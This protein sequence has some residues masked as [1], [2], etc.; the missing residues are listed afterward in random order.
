MPELEICII[1]V[2][3]IIYCIYPKYS[4]KHAWANSKDTDKILAPDKRGV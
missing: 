3:S 1:L 4:D 2:H